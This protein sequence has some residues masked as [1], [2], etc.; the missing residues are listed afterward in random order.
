M[1]DRQGR[2]SGEYLQ[3][4]SFAVDD[5]CLYVLDTFLPGLHVFDNRT[6]AYVA[7]KKMAFIAWDFETL[8]RGRMIFTFCFFKAGHLPPLST[9]LSSFDYGQRSEYY[10]TPV[11]F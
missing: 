4:K 9:F 2:G 6:G 5:S 10:S 1:I 8:S 11:A 7:K 3:I